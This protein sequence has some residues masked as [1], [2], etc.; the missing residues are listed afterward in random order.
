MDGKYTKIILAVILDIKDREHIGNLADFQRA[1]MGKTERHYDL[2]R[3][4]VNAVPP[5]G[6]VFKRFSFEGRA[7]MKE[8][9]RDGDTA[10]VII[11]N[12]H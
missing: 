2:S 1:Y 11:Y 12:I 4:V 3:S 5:V 6:S 9:D 7:D 8:L 10:E